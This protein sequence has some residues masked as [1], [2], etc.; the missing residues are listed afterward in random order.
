MGKI[1][2][3]R[4]GRVAV[5]MNGAGCRGRGV[6]PGRYGQVPGKR[7]GPVAGPAAGQGLEQLEL[8]MRVGGEGH[9][10]LPEGLGRRRP[11]FPQGMAVCR[12]AGQQKL[13]EQEKGE[14]GFLHGAKF[15]KNGPAGG[16][17]P[18]SFAYLL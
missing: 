10:V 7:R 14:T 6:A 9:G 15:S 11:G 13:Q 5:A 2:L 12:E 18:Y 4:W 1:F 16:P 8:R 17:G 3:D